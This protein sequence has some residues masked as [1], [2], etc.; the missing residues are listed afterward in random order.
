MSVSLTGLSNTTLSGVDI[1]SSEVTVIEV[2]ALH[3]QDKLPSPDCSN[4]DENNQ[5]AAAAEGSASEPGSD[6]TDSSI[7]VISD[8]PAKWF[9]ITE[10]LISYWVNKGPEQC[11]HICTSDTYLK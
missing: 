4:G 2:N 11:Q 8:D 1:H 10:G 5:E 9:P 3:K 7:D 6:S